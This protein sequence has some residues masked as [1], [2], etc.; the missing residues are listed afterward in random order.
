MRHHASQQGFT[1]IEVMVAMAIMVIGAAG[2]VGLFTTGEVMNGNARRMTRATAIAEDLV[3]NIALWPYQDNVAGSPLANT[4]ATNDGDIA[5]TAFQ[6]ETAADP[7]GS[8]LADHGEPD[9]TALGAAW[10]GIPAAELVGEYER[11][12]NVVYVDSNGDGV[13][14]LAQLAVIV[15]WKQGT[16]WRRVVLLSGKLNP[17]RR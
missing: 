16:G 14:E 10:T 6:F 3:N 9:L 1:L 4:S 15:R 2:L 5:D 11:Y 13:N 12:W 17:A 8:G 7:L